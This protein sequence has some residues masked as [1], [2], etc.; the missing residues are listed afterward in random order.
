MRPFL[1][2]SWNRAKL[3]NAGMGA[4]EALQDR[5][6]DAAG[7]IG[8]DVIDG[9]DLL[10][11]EFVRVGGDVVLLLEEEV[12]VFPQHVIRGGLAQRHV[13]RDHDLVAGGATLLA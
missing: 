2:S 4:S 13:R 5:S 6:D 7:E 8:R 3:K 9:H 11:D 10:V 12:V 1:M